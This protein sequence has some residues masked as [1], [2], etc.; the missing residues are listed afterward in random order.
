MLYFLTEHILIIYVQY[1]KRFQEKNFISFREIVRERFS[2][3]RFRE[4]FKRLK[5]DY[6]SSETVL[7][8]KIKVKN[9][10]LDNCVFLEISLTHGNQ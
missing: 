1:I 2:T 10:F 9:Y 7:N 6:S 8:Q 3:F 4:H 5:F